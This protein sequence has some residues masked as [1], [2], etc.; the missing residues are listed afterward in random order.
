M[1]ASVNRAIGANDASGKF[2]LSIAKQ[3]AQMMSA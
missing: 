3:E 2:S 1:I